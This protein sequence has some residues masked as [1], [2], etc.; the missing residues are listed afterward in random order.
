MQDASKGKIAITIV[1]DNNPYDPR[2]KTAWGFACVV[3]GME[4]TI[5]FD[6]GGDGAILLS[7]MAKLGISPGEIEVVVLSHVHGDHTGALGAFLARNSDVEVY[8]PRVF[9][10]AMKDGVRDA[11]AR[12]VEVD[13]PRKI[14]TGAYS[15]GQMGTSIKEQALYV[16]TREGIVVITGCAHPGIVGIVQ[17]AGQLSNRP[18]DLVIG[19]FHLG[20]TSDAGLRSII[21]SFKKI[22]VKRVAPCHC[23]GQRARE[24]FHQA[25]GADFIEAG[26]GTRLEIE[27][28]D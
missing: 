11:G 28:A 25:F 12:V 8:M 24:L 16:Q 26:V 19:G 22:G 21:G 5:L 20:S 14:C 1:Y 18:V 9:P 3:Q 27:K 6:T 13:E 2:L 7:N 17:R 15:T 4:K 23:S 10:Q